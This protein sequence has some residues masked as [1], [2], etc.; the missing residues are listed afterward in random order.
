MTICTQ[1]NEQP[2]VLSQEFMRI[3]EWL[4]FTDRLT[5]KMEPRQPKVDID[6][7]CGTGS[8]SMSLTN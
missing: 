8:L 7:I 3:N 2:N 4:N 5:V 1:P 6:C